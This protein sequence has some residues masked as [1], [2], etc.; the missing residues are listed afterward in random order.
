MAPSPVMTVGLEV[1]A[2]LRVPEKIFCSCPN[3]YGEPPNTL[4]CPVCLG[5]PGSLPVF[6]Q[7]A[8]VCAIQAGVAMGCT[9]HPRSEF[10]RK[11]YFYPDLPRNYQITQY[12]FPL[13]T[14]G[15]LTVGG[16]SVRLRRIHLEED[17]GRC[18]HQAGKP[19]RIDLNRAG[20][21]L[22][23]RTSDSRHRRGH[24]EGSCRA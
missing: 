23:R 11:N 7:D 13:C 9:I 22:V 3:L 15:Q 20:S 6:N 2:R 5:L 14:G 4:V 18:L 19:T 16:N 17:A 24:R 12:R 1:H 8:A 10:D 21:P